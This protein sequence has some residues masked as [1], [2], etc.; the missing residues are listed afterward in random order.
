MKIVLFVILS[1]LA[2]IG[3]AHITLEL[4]YRFF[5]IKDDNAI[6]LFA[7]KQDDLIDV[8]F[9]LRS[10]IAKTKK[11][12][13][14]GIKNIVCIDDNLSENSKRELN[15]LQKNYPYLTITNSKSFTEKAGF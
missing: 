15:I 10:I 14:N 6:L 8:E 2:I 9:A 1:F 3:A 12:G 4:L 13:K 11:L 7:P 5:K